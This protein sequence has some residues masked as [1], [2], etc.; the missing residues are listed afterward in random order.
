PS[1]VL[2]FSVQNEAGN[3]Y[4]TPAGTF[5]PTTGNDDTYSVSQGILAAGG[6]T[7]ASSSVASPVFPA[8]GVF[9]LHAR[10]R[11]GCGSDIPADTTYEFLVGPTI[12]SFSDAA[13]TIP[14][15]NFS[16]NV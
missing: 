8:R 7:S 1:V 12:D 15:E 16:I 6:T 3:Q 2:R 14:A 13:R 10:W 11:E 4:M 5:S 9:A